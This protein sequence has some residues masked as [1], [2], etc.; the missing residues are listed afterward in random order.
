MIGT[1]VDR[2]VTPYDEIDKVIVLL[3]NDK[4][5]HVSIVI[6]QPTISRLPRC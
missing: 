2:S 1:D 3:R 4:N 6:I 5:D